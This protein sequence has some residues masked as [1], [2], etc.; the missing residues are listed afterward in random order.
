MLAT[1]RRIQH[2]SLAD[3]GTMQPPIASYVFR[4]VKRAHHL[5]SLPEVPF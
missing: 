5:L 3:A 1:S 2:L 4:V